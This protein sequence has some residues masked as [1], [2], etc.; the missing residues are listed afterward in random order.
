[1]EAAKA[2]GW[3]VSTPVFDGAT[4]KDVRELLKEAGMNEDGKNNTL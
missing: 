4:E 1:M 2:L 3:K